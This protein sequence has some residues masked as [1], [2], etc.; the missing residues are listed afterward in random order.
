MLG[1]TSASRC[2]ER[3]SPSCR[4][5]R[6]RIAPERQAVL[7]RRRHQP[8]KPPHAAIRPGRPAPAMGPGTGL[9]GTGTRF[10]SNQ[11]KWSCTMPLM[12]LACELASTSPLPRP[13]PKPTAAGDPPNPLTPPEASPV[14]QRTVE[15]ANLTLPRRN[16]KIVAAKDQLE[17]VRRRPMRVIKAYVV[18]RHNELVRRA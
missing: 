5:R 6:V 9:G 15:E 12:P 1:T 2:N 18:P 14:S 16:D 4:K 17:R 10:G 3:R 11:M 7:C 13:S 8:R